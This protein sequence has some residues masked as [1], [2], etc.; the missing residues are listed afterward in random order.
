[1]SMIDFRLVRCEFDKGFTG[2][3]GAGFLR[4]SII[5]ATQAQIM[6][7]VDAFGILTFL[8]NHDIVSVIRIPRVDMI[9]TL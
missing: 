5:S 8:G 3:G 4:A 7:F 9:H 6:S 1:M 2:P